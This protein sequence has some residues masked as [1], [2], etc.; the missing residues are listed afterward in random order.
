LNW[1]NKMACEGT[2][3]AHL[4]GGTPNLKVLVP[5]RDARSLGALF[6]F[7]EYACGVS[8]LVQNVNPF[9]QPGV[10][11]YKRSVKEFLI[12]GI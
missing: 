1:I 8:A 9:D 10:E 3:K 12:K 7:F 5:T 11:E 2:M 4:A 6:Y